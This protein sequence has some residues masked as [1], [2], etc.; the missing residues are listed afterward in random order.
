MGFH[1]PDWRI[2]PLRG[3][4]RRAATKDSFCKSLDLAGESTRRYASAPM[5]SALALLQ[6]QSA[7][8]RHQGQNLFEPVTLEVA[9]GDQLC[10]LGPPGCGK[11]LLLE[12]MAGRHVLSDG[13]RCYPAWSTW[14][15]DAALGVAPRFSIQLVSTEE[16]RRVA[17][18][19]ATFH[20]ARWHALF[21]E[22]NTVESFLSGRRVIG[23]NDFELP[24]DGS[25]TADHASR[26]LD[27]L[28]QLGIEHLLYRRVAALSNGELRKLLL[29]RALLA[30][31]RLLLLDDPLG[32]LD[33]EARPR[34][35]D[36]LVRI[37]EDSTRVQ[38][39]QSRPTAWREPGEPL[40]L[41]V[42]TPRP[43]EL[44]PLVTRIVKLGSPRGS[45]PQIPQI[46]RAALPPEADTMRAAAT[47]PQVNPLAHSNQPRAVA[48]AS[49][50]RSKRVLK[51]SRAT[52][53]AGPLAILDSVT[54][55]VLAGEHWLI[56]GPNGSG[57][58][59]LLALL[60]GDH[61]QSYVAD[62]EVLGLRAGPGVPRFERQR[63][64][65]FMAP[66]LSLHYP[67]GWN[68]R[69]VVLSGFTASIGRYTDVDD[70]QL[71]QAQAWLTQLDLAKRAEVPF[72]ILTEA[73][74][75]RVLIARALVR[76]PALLI[77]DEPT[78][79]LADVERT[80]I[81]GILDAVSGTNDLTLLLVSHHPEERPRCITHHLRLEAGCVVAHGPLLPASRSRTA[82]A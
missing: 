29:A 43:E 33:P 62:L 6:L 61:P 7:T 34:V 11:S 20:Q 47:A 56:T 15:A 14:H 73:E 41:V 1:W 24:P 16:Q 44:R 27:V 59:T 48:S 21:T 5:T 60:L 2:A 23:L 12:V 53:M 63:R 68:A 77:L 80:K 42:T 32:G 40:T 46:A 66:E 75:R 31:P 72:G 64:I 82:D 17:S 8:L 26:R 3:Q 74:Q 4:N 50:G 38:P 69:D 55:E 67:A 13:H 79:G 51:L 39:A 76:Q 37:R 9:V 45:V 78:Q 52:V 35:I 58:S 22:P 71:E 19:V 10:V 65:G 36:A 70:D 18:Q 25:I 49:E 57:K 81:H 30:R 28:S 54:F